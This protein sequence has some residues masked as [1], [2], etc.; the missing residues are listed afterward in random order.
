MIFLILTFIQSY[1]ILSLIQNI[2]VCYFNLINNNDLVNIKCL[3]NFRQGK[4]T[5]M[6]FI[7]YIPKTPI[8]NTSK[9]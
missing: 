1:K 5:Q 3:L 9:N 2:D 8:T 4:E 6:G 7:R